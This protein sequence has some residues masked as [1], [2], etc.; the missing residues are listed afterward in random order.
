MDSKS[1]A[2]T[3][4]LRPKA[5]LRMTVQTGAL[6]VL[7]PQDLDAHADTFELYCVSTNFIQLVQLDKHACAF[8]SSGLPEIARRN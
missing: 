8:S 3:E 6:D 1:Y 5:G 2:F 7:N 4:I